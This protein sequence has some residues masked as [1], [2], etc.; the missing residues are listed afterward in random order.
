MPRIQQL[1]AVLVNQIAAGEVVERPASVL[2]ELLENA[3][4][5]GATRIDADVAQGGLDLIRVVDDG[6]GIEADDLPLALASHATSKLSSV[7]DLSRVATL[8]FRG[9]ALASVRG[10]PAVPLPPAAAVPQQRSEDLDP[11]RKAEPAASGKTGAGRALQ[12]PDC[13]LVV[14]VPPDEFLFLDQHAL[15]ERIPFEQPSH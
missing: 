7:E 5:A 15:H 11:V 14:E 3:V 13:Y 9:E 4:D 10:A 12:V 6:C 2:K 1:P 8:G